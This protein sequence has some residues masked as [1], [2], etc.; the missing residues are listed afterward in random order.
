MKW[1]RIRKTIKASLQ[2]LRHPRTWFPRKPLF[3]ISHMR[4]YS[5]LLT[6]ILGSNPQ[7]AGGREMLQSYRDYSDLVKL[8]VKCR[9]WTGELKPFVLDKIL[10]D[11]YVVSPEFLKKYDAQVLFT[12]REP[13]PAITSIKTLFEQYKK[14]TYSE[15]ELVQYYVGRLQTLRTLSDQ[16]KDHTTTPLAFHADDVVNHSEET[17][18]FLSQSLKLH[19]PLCRTYA[20]HQETGKMNEGDPSE[21]IKAGKILKPSA[22]ESDDLLKVSS[23]HE[24]MLEDAY[25]KTLESLKVNCHFMSHS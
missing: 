15:E 14:T 8:Q 2:T 25:Q 7:I 21:N 18:D 19:T 16:I 4:S 1:N 11:Q 17:L 24:V 22:K 20:L 6:H 23:L 5:T 10:N 3:V 9:K 13:L 12:I